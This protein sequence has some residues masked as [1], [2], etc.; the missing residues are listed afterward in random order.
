[1]CLLVV[2]IGG[3]WKA[4]GPRSCEQVIGKGFVAYR[5]SPRQAR[6]VLPRWKSIGQEVLS[7]GFESYLYHIGIA[8][9]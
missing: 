4:A 3:W 5:E 7:S 2:V 6:A 9:R 8:V 1:M